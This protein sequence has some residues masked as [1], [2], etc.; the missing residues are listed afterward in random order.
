L[1]RAAAAAPL[2][3]TGSYILIAGVMSCPVIALGMFISRRQ[4]QKEFKEHI[5]DDTTDFVLFDD[6][7]EGGAQ[8]ELAKEPPNTQTDKKNIVDGIS[9]AT[10]IASIPKDDCGPVIL[11]GHGYKSKMKSYHDESNNVGASSNRDMAGT[12]TRN[13]SLSTSIGKLQNKLELLRE[14]EKQ[15]Q[16]QHHG[17]AGATRKILKDELQSL[18][19]QKF[20]IKQK[21]KAAKQTP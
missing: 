9:T 12:N 19:T 10:N 4:P 7:T 2:K 15:L 16:L 3:N 8:E 17:M 11:T 20:S 13:Q 6:H 5:V 21:I 1:E 14:Q 18:K